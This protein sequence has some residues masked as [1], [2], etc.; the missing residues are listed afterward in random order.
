VSAIIS[1]TLASSLSLH[2]YA[3]CA[4]QL[5][6]P[7]RLQ[8]RKLL[9]GWHPHAFGGLPVFHSLALL[10]SRVLAHSSLLHGSSLPSLAR[11]SLILCPRQLRLKGEAPYLLHS[12]H[13]HA[14]WRSSSSPAP[15][16]P[17]AFTTP[18]LV[19]SFS[20]R[21]YSTYAIVSA[22]IPLYCTPLLR[23]NTQGQFLA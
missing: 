19:P 13:Q 1:L 12:Q 17:M 10:H 16:I 21:M 7:Q 11:C 9:P 23:Q 3:D 14:R 20:E 18:C 22:L 15:D 4:A 2:P 6:I 8:P 5:F